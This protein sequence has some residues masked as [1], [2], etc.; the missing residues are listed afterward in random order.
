MKR[1]TGL[2]ILAVLL[3]CG[4]LASATDITF[5]S[6]NP[7]GVIGDGDS[8]GLVTL[9]DSA[10]VTMTGGSLASGIVAYDTSTFNLQGGSSGSG[11]GFYNSSIANI[12]GGTAGVFNM[13]DDSVLNISGGTVY[14]ASMGPSTILNLSGGTLRGM[15]YVKS[16]VNIY[17]RDL[18]VAPQ[19]D[20]EV[21]SGHW[22]DD[23]PFQFTLGRALGYS[24]PTQINFYEVPEPASMLLV[25]FGMLFIQKKHS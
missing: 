2:I 3:C 15:Y 8:Y 18:S 14:G 23:T 19:Q 12:T 13:Y 11:A 17:A 22:A 9:H 10:T 6:S 5:D 24:P 20:N 1:S 7:V 4:G 21:A 16:T 25:G